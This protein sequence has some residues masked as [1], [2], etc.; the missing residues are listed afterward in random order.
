MVSKHKQRK[1]IHKASGFSN[2]KLYALIEKKLKIFVKNKKRM[3]TE[4]ELQHFQDIQLLDNKSKQS[5][6]NIAESTKSGEIYSSSFQWNSGSDRELFVTCL[7]DNS[8]KLKK[9]IEN[10]LDLFIDTSLNHISIR[11]H[12]VSQPNKNLKSNNKNYLMPWIYCI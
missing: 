2:R 11:S 8:D 7:N 1:K 10:Y 6:I 3:K 5:I 4:K 12:L 9:P